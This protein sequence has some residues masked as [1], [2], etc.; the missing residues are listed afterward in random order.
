VWLLFISD[1]N[2]FE[3]YYCI[4]CLD[5]KDT[6]GNFFS[7][8]DYGF[9]FAQGG[10][11]G[12]ESFQGSNAGSWAAIPN[13]SGLAITP[14]F[15][16]TYD[17]YNSTTNHHIFEF[18]IPCSL[19]GASYSYGI[20]LSVSGGGTLVQWPQNA[21]GVE[22]SWKGNNYVEGV[23]APD[24]WGEITSTTQFAETPPPSP[25]SSPTEAPTSSPTETATPSPIQ[26]STST[27]AVTPQVTEFPVLAV[28]LILLAAGLS[29][30]I[31]NRRKTSK[32]SS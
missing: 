25:S 8:K 31:L 11:G 29:I 10:L 5:T 21:G 6:G 16:S 2:S 28:M 17:P 24:N 32:D 30:A 20:Y 3:S 26:T 23:P 12:I 14:G 1:T 15:S 22:F 7:A 13:P 19:L 27:P 18:Q 4:A 9:A